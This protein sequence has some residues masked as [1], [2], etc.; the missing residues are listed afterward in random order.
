MLRGMAQV[1]IARR[2]LEWC[3]YSIV[4]NCVQALPGCRS[5]VAANRGLTFL[6]TQAQTGSL[7]HEIQEIPQGI[8]EM[9]NKE[10]SHSVN[11]TN[12]TP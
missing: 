11:L 8:Q 2:S 4:H 7:R 12:R 5:N 3:V 10:F 9:Y 6:V 1:V